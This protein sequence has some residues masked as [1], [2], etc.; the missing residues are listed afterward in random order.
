MNKQNT[1]KVCDFG[2]CTQ[3]RINFGALPKTEYDIAQ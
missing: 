2:S 1:L 3:E